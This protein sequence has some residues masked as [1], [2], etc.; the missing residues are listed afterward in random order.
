MGFS[1][2]GLV[3]LPCLSRGFVDQHGARIAIDRQHLAMMYSQCAVADAEH[4]GNAIFA[5]DDGAVRQDAAHVGNEADRVGEE[6]C[7]G[8]RGVRRHE[9]RAGGTSCRT[10][11]GKG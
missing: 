9:N 2:K 10:P 4:G 7:P 5:R 1:K 6:L 3:T 11:L 8:R